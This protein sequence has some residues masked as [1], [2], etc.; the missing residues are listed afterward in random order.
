MKKTRFIPYGYTVRNGKT[1]IEH[2]EADIIKEI[3]EQ[4][5]NG[6]S[7]KDIAE[8][9]TARKIPYTEKTDV[10]DKARIARI[11][12][13]AKYI[14]DGAY[15]P[16]IDEKTYEIAV[17]SKIAR[18]RGYQQ[19]ENEAVGI[20]RNNVRCECCGYPMVRRICQKAK[21]KESWTCTNP[22]CGI[23]VRLRDSELIAK[24]TLLINRIIENSELMIPKPKERHKDSPEVARIQQDINAELMRDRPSEDLIVSKIGDIASVL[25]RESD[26]KRDITAVIAKKHA[27]MMQ[28]TETFTKDYY[29]DLVAYLTLDQS[30]KVTL[31]TKTETEL[32]EGDEPN[33]SNQDTE[34]NGNAD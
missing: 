6:E 2:A 11:I 14:G 28:P 26:A 3:F 8:S 16:I 9:L 23:R 15:D 29:Y 1:V 10:W 34:E 18:Q 31:H 21:I 5:V 12:D 7:L 32:S 30:G 24:V 19:A 13:N 17:A 25:Y 4:Y 20:L 27:S 33:G 22:E